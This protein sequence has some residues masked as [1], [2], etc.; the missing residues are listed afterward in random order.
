MNFF[1]DFGYGYLKASDQNGNCVKFPSVFGEAHESF[2][3]VGRTSKDLSIITSQGSWLFGNDALEQSIT[4]SHSQDRK[5]ILSSEFKAGILLAISKLTNASRIDASLVLSLPYETA[6]QKQLV[7]DMI[8]NLE[9]EERISRS[10]QPGQKVILS[11]WDKFPVIPQNISPIARNFSDKYGNRKNVGDRDLALVGL[12][13]IGS[14]T[15]EL[16]TVRINNKTGSFVGINGMSKSLGTYALGNTIRPILEFAFPDAAS[17]L[18]KDHILFDVISTGKFNPFNQSHD[19]TNYFN[20]PLKI[21]NKS[22]IAACH[23]FWADTAPIKRPELWGVVVS[24]G[25]AYVS[26]DALREFHPNVIVSDNPQY[27]VVEGM[28]RIRMMIEKG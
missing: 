8:V 15:V 28:R 25:G 4:A 2:F 18:K 22:I 20:S 11:V 26:A 9:G 3:D 6:Q 5:W 1:I 16:S 12:C 21:Y 24:G 27:D 19:V 13:N 14:H 23:N 7:K 17:L 10:G